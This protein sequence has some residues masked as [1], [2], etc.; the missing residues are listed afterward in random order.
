ML[1]FPSFWW[2]AFS[3]AVKAH[4]IYLVV[5][6]FIFNG[7]SLFRGELSEFIF[8]GA[9]ASLVISILFIIYVAFNF[10]IK[11]FKDT[12]FRANL[13]SKP[14]VDTARE[15]LGIKIDEPQITECNSLSKDLPD[16]T[17]KLGFTFIICMGLVTIFGLLYISYLVANK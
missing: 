17:S 4:W 2:N 13:T 5:F 8:S 10:I 16:I 6:S 14:C 9:L 11:V 12:S 7:S 3:L 15:I 1:I